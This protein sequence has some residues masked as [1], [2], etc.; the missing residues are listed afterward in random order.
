MKHR[1]RSVIEGGGIRWKGGLIYIGDQ[2]SGEPFGLKRAT[3]DTWD[4]WLGPAR[5]GLADHTRPRLS[6]IYKKVF[7]MSP[8]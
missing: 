2:F 8:V 3:E 5:F 7:P 6:L 4:V 1:V